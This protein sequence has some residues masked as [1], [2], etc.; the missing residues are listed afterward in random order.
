MLEIER[1]ISM[2]S[3]YH[4]HINKLVS[5][6]RVR[7]ILQ[8]LTLKVKLLIREVCLM[9]R[10]LDLKNK[11]LDYIQAKDDE[12]TLK[13]MFLLNGLGMACSKLT[14]NLASNTTSHEEP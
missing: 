12:L 9:S 14:S 1:F 4:T 6:W 3:Y 7:S 11:D 5:T 2:G 13:L 8:Q 10:P